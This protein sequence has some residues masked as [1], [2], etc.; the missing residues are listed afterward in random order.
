[1]KLDAREIMFPVT[2]SSQRGT[3][4]QEYS[5]KKSQI[6]WKVKTF[7]YLYLYPSVQ[8]SNDHI[9]DMM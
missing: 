6:G 4:F 9:T 1:M 7:S 2:E 8:E 5:K 3:S